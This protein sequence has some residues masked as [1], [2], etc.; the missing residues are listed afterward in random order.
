[1]CQEILYPWMQEGAPMIVCSLM[2]LLSLHAVH[3]P[4]LCYVFVLLRSWLSIVMSTSW[5][6]RALVS[7]RQELL[8]DMPVLH[9]EICGLRMP[10]H[11]HVSVHIVIRSMGSLLLM[12]AYVWYLCLFV[13]FHAWKV[14]LWTWTRWN[15]NLFSQKDMNATCSWVDKQH[16]ENRAPEIC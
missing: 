13:F 5:W 12:G 6:L 8:P 11:H 7:I 14:I 10:H 15:S 9:W 2:P 4:C 3:A 16:L 1:M